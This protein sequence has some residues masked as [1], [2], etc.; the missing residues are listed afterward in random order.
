[1]TVQTRARHPF[2][3]LLREYRQ[4][5][6]GLSQERLAHRI[7]YDQSVL[8]RMSQG[9]KDLT[10]PSGRERVVLLI[11]ALH[12]F[13]VLPT[14]DEANALLLAADMP[15]LF[16]RQPMEARLLARLSP[17]EANQKRRLRSN[18]PAPIASF[19]GR[20]RELA[21][22]R[23]LLGMTRLLTLTGAGGCGKTRLAQHAAADALPAYGDGVWQIELATLSDA[24]RIPDM[25][26]RALGLI[27]FNTSAMELVLDHLAIRHTLLLIDNCE[28]LLK[29]V[30]LF[31][32]ALL[33]ACPHVTLLTTS[34]EMLNV[35]GET[36]WRVPP[37]QTA[38]AGLLFVHRAAA[39]RPDILL[40]PHE[41]FVEQICTRLDGMP[42]AI[43]LAAVRLQNMGLAEL[44]A[45]LDDRFNL[46]AH[47]R[48]GALTRH[49]TLRALID[50]SHDA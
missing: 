34:R 13:G 1:M 22:I 35:E 8:V 48:V 49:Q 42:L 45:K 43:E 39:I 7:G 46:L 18:L 26:A 9:K 19:V 38:E 32:I 27:G 47:G 41:P 33:Q 50:W 24:E 40:R 5:K 25:V 37:L 11:E 12:E 36:T 30:A 4:R 15:P 14:L 3:E 10:G 23:A 44:A 2:G 31:T 16:E 28:H 21:E 17:S 20:E 29:P 6:P